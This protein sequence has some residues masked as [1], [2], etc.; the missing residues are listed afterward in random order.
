MTSEMLSSLLSIWM[1]D[2]ERE[3]TSQRLPTP[4]AAVAPAAADTDGTTE[5]SFVCLILTVSRWA[6]F[7]SAN[8]EG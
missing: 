8:L 1:N 5:L 6:H 3:E 4:V 7:N 2:G